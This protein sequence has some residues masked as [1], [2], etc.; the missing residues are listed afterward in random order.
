MHGVQGQGAGRRQKD[1][2]TE[3]QQILFK[4]F[5]E[6]RQP[7]VGL[8]GLGYLLENE[9]VRE[10]EIVMLAGMMRDSIALLDERTKDLSAYIHS[11][12]I[13]LH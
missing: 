1:S 3:I 6:V 2:H 12:E 9:M 4:I 7:V 5:H 10:E 11:L 8:Q 13:S